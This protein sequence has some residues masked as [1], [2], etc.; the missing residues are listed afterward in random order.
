MFGDHAGTGSYLDWLEESGFVPQW[1]W[2][3]PEGDGGHSLI[4]ARVA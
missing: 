4:L 3:I 1:D 2:F